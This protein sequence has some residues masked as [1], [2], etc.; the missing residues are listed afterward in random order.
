MKEYLKV[1]IEEKN[2]KIQFGQRRKQEV[3]K[4]NESNTV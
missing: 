1:K 2:H 4:A 3:N